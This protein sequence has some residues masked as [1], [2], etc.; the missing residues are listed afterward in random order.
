MESRNTIIIEMTFKDR[1]ETDLPQINA[2]LAT[3]P[4]K[5]LEVKESRGYLAVTRSP[6]GTERRYGLDEARLVCHLA[7]CSEEGFCYQID[8][9]TY[10]HWEDE[11]GLMQRW[12]ET[13]PGRILCMTITRCYQSCCCC[14]IIHRGTGVQDLP[15]TAPTRRRGM[16]LLDRA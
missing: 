9:I 1:R 14:M 4:L 12:R 6:Q 8:A 15:H 16:R 2:L 7:D 5:E 3:M 11:D 10:E 13:H